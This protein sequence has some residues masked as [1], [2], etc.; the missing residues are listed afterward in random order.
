[1]SD[2]NNKEYLDHDLRNKQNPSEETFANN[3]SNEPTSPAHQDEDVMLV[4]P[5]K[6]KIHCDDLGIFQTP[7]TDTGHSLE[8]PE[9]LPD[10]VAEQWLNEKS[11]DNKHVGRIKN[12]LRGTTPRQGI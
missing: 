12:A 7:P 9:P 6:P 3:P 4:S 8:K 10:G 1:M 11:T 2:D 5:S